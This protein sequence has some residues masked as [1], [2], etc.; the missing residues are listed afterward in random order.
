M[1]CS[2]TLYSSLSLV[3]LHLLT[4]SN[5]YLGTFLRN[6]RGGSLKMCI[7]SHFN[8]YGVLARNRGRRFSETGFCGNFL[9]SRDGAEEFHHFK[10]FALCAPGML[11]VA[12]ICNFS[13]VIS[14][15][16]F[17]LQCLS[18]YGNSRSNFCYTTDT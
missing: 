2:V 9:A 3:I 11:H 17:L 16:S 10:I 15:T 6:N 7:L 8:E 5:N 12:T 1:K 18:T 4:C 13:N 14:G